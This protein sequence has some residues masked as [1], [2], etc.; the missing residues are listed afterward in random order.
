MSCF[1]GTYP[2]GSGEDETPLSCPECD[3]EVDADG[4]S[5]EVCEYSPPECDTCGWAPC[6]GSC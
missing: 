1:G 4:D 3:S 5:I 2:L 6:D